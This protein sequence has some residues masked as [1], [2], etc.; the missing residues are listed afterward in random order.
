MIS[1]KNYRKI[2][3]KEPEKLN[4]SGVIINAVEVW[5]G[6][7]FSKDCVNVKINNRCYISCTWFDKYSSQT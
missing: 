5:E 3:C 2:T 6:C 7:P 1:L 4:I